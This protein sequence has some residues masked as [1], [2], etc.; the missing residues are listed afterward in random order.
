MKR[1]GRIL[2]RWGY[3]LLAVLCAAVIILSALWTRSWQRE[4]S[5]NAEALSDASERLAERTTAPTAMPLIRPLGGEILRGY[6]GAPVYDPALRVWMIHPALD[7]A[8][9][10]GDKVLAMA[11]GTAEAWADGVAIDHGG[12]RRSVYRGLRE[13]AVQPG[14]RVSAGAVIGTA[15]GRVPFEGEGRVCVMLFQGDRPLDF[16]KELV[17]RENK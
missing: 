4:E 2:D 3:Y 9:E 16:L 7:F 12:G 6:S 17:D 5:R 1:I 15:G 10:E 14:Q 8:A 11:D 13:I